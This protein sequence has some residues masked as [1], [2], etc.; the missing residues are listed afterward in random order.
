MKHTEHQTLNTK[1]Q[2][3]NTKNHT[4]KTIHQKQNTNDK[5]SV[6]KSN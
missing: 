3:L 4:P 2:T 6:N 1:H 5:T